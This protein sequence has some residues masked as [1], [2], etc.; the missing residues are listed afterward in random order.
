MDHRLHVLVVPS[1]FP[2]TVAPVDG[3]YVRD[4]VQMLYRAGVR[5]AVLYPELRSWRTISRKPLANYFQT[6]NYDEGGVETSRIHAWNIPRAKIGTRIWLG[7]VMKLVKSYSERHGKPD[8]CHAHNCHWAGLSARMVKRAYGIPYVITEHSTAYARGLLTS[9]QAEDARDALAEAD[10]ILAVSDS[11]KNFLQPYAIGKT[12]NTVSNVV[13]TEFFR[14]PADR[15]RSS[16]FRFLTVA[17]LVR[18]KGIDDLIHAF[19][20]L[21]DLQ[22]SFTL[23]IGGDGPERPRLENLTHTLRLDDRIQFLGKLD[24]YGVREAMWRADAFVLPSHVETFGV[25]LIEAMAT[26]LPVVA[27][28]SGGPEEFV[29]DEVG[30]LVE[31]KSPPAL[32]EALLGIVRRYSDFDKSR[33]RQYAKER[34]GE[35]AISDQVISIYRDILQ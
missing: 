22:P 4:Q 17:H 19:A 28:R 25:V 8:L 33:L 31:T 27:T 26:G 6:R 34:F 12:L 7:L 11:L 21:R 29:N 1:L 24:R 2:T 14:A 5:V 10:R 35:L 30:F 3:V 20:G 15:P 23:E 16:A 18:H 32:A 13:D 9:W